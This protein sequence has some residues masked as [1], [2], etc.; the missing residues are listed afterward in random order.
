MTGKELFIYPIDLGTLVGIDKSV[1]TN[2]QNEG[3]KI[4]VPCIGWLILGGEK[5]VLV[6]TGP[7]DS[8]R[9]DRYHRPIK[10]SSAQE[11]HEALAKIGVSAQDIDVVIFTH[12]HWDHCFNLE[13]FTKA[14]FFVQRKEIRY[15]V[16]P[17]PSDRKPYEAG[18]PGLQP[19]WMN[20]FGRFTLVDGD[21]RILPGIRVIYLP[22]HTP[23]SQG[24]VVETSGG[25][26]V[27]AGDN[28]PLYENWIGD[29]RP[30]HIPSG[31]YQNLYDC[32]DSLRRL[33]VY[34]SQVLPSHDEKVFKHSRYPISKGEN[35]GK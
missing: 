19:P 7:C 29:N 2:L 1:F 8:D 10:K 3:V 18:E 6:D 30:E 13:S 25:E 35:E 26:W 24:V 21:Q 22:G 33:E 28:V 20:V 27:I 31:V 14:T 17:L 12:L 9:A 4:N 32:Y 16:S 23:G 5:T 15:A 34:G 11:V